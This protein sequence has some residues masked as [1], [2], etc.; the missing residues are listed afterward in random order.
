LPSIITHCLNNEIYFKNLDRNE[1]A[2]GSLFP[3]FFVFNNVQLRLIQSIDSQTG[4][5][6]VYWPV[7][8]PSGKTI[9]F[10]SP[11]FE[12]ASKE[13]F[14]ETGWEKDPVIILGS[15]DKEFPYWIYNIYSK[16]SV[17]HILV[18]PIENNEK[19]GS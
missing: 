19:N 7:K 12:T 9:D 8:D 15:G 17:Q 11:Q 14:Q 13:L 16:Y 10:P 1:D 5:F 2:W 18:R 4:Q 6:T 3:Q